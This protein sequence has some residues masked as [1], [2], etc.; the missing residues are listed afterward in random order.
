MM[1]V[2]SASSAAPICCE[3]LPQ[4]RRFGRLEQKNVQ[5]RE[6]ICCAAAEQGRYRVVGYRRRRK[7]RPHGR[8]KQEI[9]S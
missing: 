3:P 9:D 4:N 2:S 5:H 7:S 1:A 8:L 6:E